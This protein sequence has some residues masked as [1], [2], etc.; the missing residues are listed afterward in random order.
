MVIYLVGTIISKPA[1]LRNQIILLG[2]YPLFGYIVQ[3]AILQIL[4][5]SLRDFDP[6]T[7]LLALTFLAAVALLVLAVFAAD[8]VRARSLLIDRFYKGIFA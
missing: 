5:R 2:R 1:V 4:R 8:R 6:E 7:G 3:I